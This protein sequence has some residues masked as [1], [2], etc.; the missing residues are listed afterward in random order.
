L[1]ALVIPVGSGFFITK[2][3]KKIHKIHGVLKLKM[4]TMNKVEI[5]WDGLTLTSAS[6]SANTIGGVEDL[7]QLICIEFNVSL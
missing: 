2:I 7:G 5:I 6:A 4:V 1:V 3:L